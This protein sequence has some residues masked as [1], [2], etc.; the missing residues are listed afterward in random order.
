MKTGGLK[1]KKD[2]MS[3]IVIFT[4]IYTENFTLKVLISDN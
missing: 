1:D 3:Q 2:V 4:S